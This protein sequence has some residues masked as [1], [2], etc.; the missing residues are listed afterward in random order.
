ME[1]DHKALCKACG[2]LGCSSGETL[3]QKITFLDGG[4]EQEF[5]LRNK[6]IATLL[7]SAKA[8]IDVRR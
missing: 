4:M 2:R 3:E 7:F 1:I 5:F 6:K 8:M